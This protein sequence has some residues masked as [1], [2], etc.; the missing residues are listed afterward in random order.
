MY[1]YIYNSVLTLLPP[2]KLLA[3]FQAHSS[4]SHVKSFG[5]PERDNSRGSQVRIAPRTPQYD[6]SSQFSNLHACLRNLPE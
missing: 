5:F 2:F 3:L 6:G 4:P 1:K